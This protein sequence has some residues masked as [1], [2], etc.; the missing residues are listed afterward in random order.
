MRLLGSLLVILLEFALSTR[1]LAQIPDCTG[2]T[3]L[4]LSGAGISDLSPLATCTSLEQLFLGNNE[5]S[6]ISPLAGLE[7]LRNLNLESNQIT[8]I[9]PLDGLTQLTSL[10]LGSNQISDI[11]ALGGLT[12][13]T[14]LRLQVNQISDITALSGLTQ[15]TSLRLHFNQISDITALVSTG[16]G[17]GDYVDLRQ[18]PLSCDPS[19]LVH[20]PALEARG[21]TVDW[22]D[23]G[24]CTD[25]ADEDGTPDYADNCIIVPNGPLIPDAGG[26]SQLDTDGDL[27]GNACDCD[28]DQNGT[29]NIADFSIFRVDF[30][31]TH[32]SGVGTDMDGSGRVG[33]G[34]F[35]LFREGFWEAVPGPS[36]LVP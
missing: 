14:S 1:V 17:D 4:D 15:L 2:M 32:D 28:F 26:H 27:Y 22:T 11:T 35:S 24:Q 9:G 12:Q 25:D 3:S 36:G 20:I 7:N 10:E 31:D 33:I 16:L 18:N 8:D 6:D 29:C 13:L 5:I 34:D 19:I 23:T 21:I 30:W